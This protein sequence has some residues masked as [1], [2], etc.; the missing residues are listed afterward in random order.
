MKVAVA[1]FPS[2]DAE[3]LRKVA[4]VSAI[5]LNLRLE[6]L[7]TIRSE[8]LVTNRE[9]PEGRKGRELVGRET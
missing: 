5:V 4:S 3:R 7:G 1:V 2:S 9:S 6:K 8:G